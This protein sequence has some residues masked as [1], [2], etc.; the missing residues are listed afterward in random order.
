MSL[1]EKAKQRKVSILNITLLLILRALQL[2]IASADDVKT[3]NPKKGLNFDGGV[4]SCSSLE[5]HTDSSWWYT[6][7]VYNGFTNTLQSFCPD[8]STAADHARA[9]G[10]DFVPMFCKFY[11]FMLWIEQALN[12]LFSIY[13][14]LTLLNDFHL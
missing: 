14:P 4:Q 6:W 1:N 2:Q 7:G 5:P 13:T 9:A 11:F 8:G 12:I 3:R 10:M